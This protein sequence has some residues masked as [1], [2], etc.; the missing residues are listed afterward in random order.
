VIIDNKIES[1]AS[2]LENG[3]PIT[4]FIGQDQDEMLSVLERYLISL[5]DLPD[6]RPVILN[7]FFLENL[8]EMR[9]PDINELGKLDSSMM[10]DEDLDDSY[11]ME[12]DQI[13]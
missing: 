11:G 2:N 1:Y 8:Q 12:D 3:I 13:F 9:Y 7:D 6:V 5:K 10:D 4:D